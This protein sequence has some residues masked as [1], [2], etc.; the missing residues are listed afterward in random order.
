MGAIGRF[1]RSLD[2]RNDR[3]LARTQYAGR[4]SASDSV[5]YGRQV[6]AAKQ[7]ERDRKAK[8]R[9]AQRE[10]EDSARRRQRHR[11]AVLRDGDKQKPV[12]KRL[13]GRAW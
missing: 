11:T 10:A 1:L 12:P 6:R 7:A 2:G 13:R 4:T 5:T 9:K 3:E 8:E